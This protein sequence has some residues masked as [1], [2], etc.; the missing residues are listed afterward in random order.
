M[1][2]DTPTSAAVVD[3]ITAVGSQSTAEAIIRAAVDGARADTGA[4]ATFA[5]VLAP[6]GSY[7]MRTLNGIVEPRFPTIQILPDMGLGGQVLTGRVPLTVDDY[8]SAPGISG[9]FKEIVGS[10]GLRGVAC[11]PAVAPTGVEFL[12]YASNR[13]PGAPGDVTTARLMEYARAA[14][15]GI[16]HVTQRE[17][18]A[19]LIVARERQRLATRLHD[20]VA[21]SLFAI[22]VHAR[23][24]RGSTDIALL[25]ECL[26]EIEQTATTTRSEL[27]DTLAR[28][29]ECSHGISFE[30]LF[31][32]ELRLFERIAGVQPV[33]ARRGDSRPLT[34]DAEELLLDTLR[35]GLR[36]VIK[37]GRTMAAVVHLGFAG[38][39]VRL[40]VQC[41]AQAPEGCVDL[42][43]GSGL[44]MLRDRA[45]RL[46]GDLEL[47]IDDSGIAVLRV[48]LPAP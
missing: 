33:N 16:H 46:N 13:T 11:V 8:S 19:Q 5:A 47:Q 12:L 18:D 32:A 17:R 10:D 28:L 36:N 6:G 31:A 40:S 29:S 9:D 42:V 22:G 48:D 39:R 43:H 34:D 2:T 30:A 45:R 44:G 37:H 35:E 3:P 41:E 21:Q 27:R 20:S 15:I 38:E 1:L 26:D 23:R 7:D 14:A 24:S 4:D 25:E